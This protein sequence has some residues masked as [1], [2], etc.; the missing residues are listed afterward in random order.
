MFAGDAAAFGTADKFP[1][2]AT[3]YRLTEHFHYWTKHA[4]INA[5]LQPEEFIEIG[6]ALAKEKGI[7]QGDWVKLSSNRGFVVAK[8]YVTKRHQAD[9]GRR[10]AMHTIGMPIHWGFIGRGPQGLR[11]Q[12]A[13]PVRRRRQCGNPE[14]KAFL[15]NVEK[16]AGRRWPEG[17]RTWPISS[18]ST[19]SAAP[20]PP[21]PRRRCARSTEVAKLIDVTKCIGCKACQAACMEW[22]DLA[23]RSGTTD[24][25]YD[26]PADL[27]PTSWT[28]MRFTE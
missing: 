25:S 20:P 4:T 11:R 14:F 1:Y 27:T 21:I 18:R 23:R 2:V 19:S 22:N 5:I 7:G 17:E 24:G 13:D 6:E 10:Q 9:D 3:T 28:L 26:N 16:T 12:H 8:A 15:V